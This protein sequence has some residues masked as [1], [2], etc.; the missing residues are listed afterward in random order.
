MCKSSDETEK[1]ERMRFDCFEDEILWENAR[2][3]FEKAARWAYWERQD[4]WWIYSCAVITCCRRSIALSVRNNEPWIQEERR[5]R[6]RTGPTPQG[7]SDYRSQLVESLACYHHWKKT[8]EMCIN[9]DQK[10]YVLHLPVNFLA[11]ILF[12]GVLSVNLNCRVWDQAVE[13]SGNARSLNAEVLQLTEL[14]DRERKRS[15]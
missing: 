11:C 6:T 7:E 5:A 2:I 1:L 4:Y 14:T 15:E 3:L 10:L 12:E 9:I 13:S 8:V